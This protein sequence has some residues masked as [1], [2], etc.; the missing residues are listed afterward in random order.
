MKML[1]EL[2]VKNFALIEELRLK[3]EGGLTVISG[4]TGT[5]KS[6][7]VEALGLL[8]GERADLDLIR[9]GSGEAVIE[10][11]FDISSN[12]KLKKLLGEAGLD[13][14]N[15][16]IL[17]RIL[18]SEGRSR[19]YANGRTITLSQLEELTRP[20]VDLSGQHESQNLLKTEH[21]LSLLDQ[22]PSIQKLLDDYKTV[23]DEF[24]Q[25]D[26]EITELKQKSRKKE[27]EIDFLRFQLKEIGE[28]SLEN[29][30]EEEKLL[31]EKARVQHASFFYELTAQAE[32]S[33]TEGES[34]VVGQLGNLLSKLKKGCDWD[35]CL[36]EGFELTDQA[37][38]YAEEASF[39]IS[40]YK[41]KIDVE[42]G[43]AEEIESRLYL[44]HKLKK[45]FGG[46]IAEI[47]KKRDEMANK[48]DQ[49][50]NFDERL[51]DLQKKWGELSQKLLDCA[52]SLSSERSQK[53]RLLEKG[54]TRELAE[55]AMEKVGF[56]VVVK[57]AD[58]P[59]PGQCTLTGFDQVYFEMAPNAGEGYKSLVQ[60]ASGGELSR[61][62]LAIKQ[63]LRSEENTITYLFDEVDAGIG[64]GTADV[65]GRKLKKLAKASQVICI[66]HLPQVASHA[67]HHYV[68]EKG[69]ANKRTRTT[70]RPVEGTERENE[71]ARMLGGVVVSAKA[72]EHAREML[73][74]SQK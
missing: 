63:I 8:L 6:I 17:R 66:T 3:F 28:A 70:A 10:A 21:H 5:G 59:D 38:R 43:R 67:D 11:I 65:V 7:L 24:K 18:I 56:R 13:E 26:H 29:D 50:E 39:F 20:L 60:I 9:T 14:G 49:F 54:I 53:A 37:R 16:L 44:I 61:I 40:R 69:E 32:T 31:E 33:L 22:D 42:P 30:D 2:Y 51:S 48:L 12:N 72:R 25:V 45:K 41:N 19:I 52:L 15:E 68:I 71:L 55:L 4:E 36:K 23:Y 57:R 27:E 74:L 62:L 46:S 73:R 34:A 47:K 1:T 58:T 35:P 64:G